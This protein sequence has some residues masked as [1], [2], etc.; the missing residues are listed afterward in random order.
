MMLA[1]GERWTLLVLGEWNMDVSDIP[2][3]TSRAPTTYCTVI[4]LW[5]V[6]TDTNTVRSL[7][8]D[9]TMTTVAAPKL[10]MIGIT[11]VIAAYANADAVIIYK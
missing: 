10:R 8:V 2:T 7:R 4:C 1:L 3:N 11:N 9:V 6:T 5:R